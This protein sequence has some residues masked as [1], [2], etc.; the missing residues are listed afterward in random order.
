[1]PTILESVLRRTGAARGTLYLACPPGPTLRRIAHWNAPDSAETI[2]TGASDP[3]ARALTTGEPL[4]T[5]GRRLDVPIAEGNRVVGV[6]AVEWDVRGLL[7]DEHTALARALAD[8][9]ALGVGSAAAR[10][11]EDEFGVRMTQLR[12]AGEKIAARLA[13][14][15]ETHLWAAVHRG[16]RLWPHARENALPEF[17]LTVL[18]TIVEQARIAVDAELAAL[19]IGGDPERPFDP[20]VYAGMSAEDATRIGRVPRPIGLF[21]I[22][23]REGHTVRLRDVR[24]HPSFGGLP[25]HHPEVRSFLAVPIVYRGISLGNIYLGNKRGA[26]EFAIEDQYILE[27]LASQAAMV[28]QHAYL[29]SAAEAQQA[30][31][32]GLLECAPIGILF[33]DAHTGNVV[34]NPRA[35]DLVGPIS[36]EA[37][38]ALVAAR[39][40][41]PDG[42]PISPEALIVPADP[43]RELIAIRPDATALPLFQRVTEV[44]GLDQRVI[45]LL[46]LLEDISPL[47]EI[48]RLREE[49]AAM[50]AHDL[51]NPIQSI[52]LQIPLLLSRAEDGEA[53]VPVA[54]LQRMERTA[55]ALALMVAELLDATRL[56]LRRLSL[57]RRRVDVPALAAD[58]VA[59][60]RM[61]V[62]A[63]EL[64]VR[65]RGT[66]PQADLDAL[67]FDQILTNLVENAAKFSPVGTRIAV[68]VVGADG[69]VEVSVSDEGPGIPQDE[70]PRLFDRFY[71]AET[72]RRRQTGL[73]LGL[74]LYITHGLVEAHGGRIR[75]ESQ[76]GRGTVFRMWFPAAPRAVDAVVAE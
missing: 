58:V 3:A 30:Q 59:R 54:A 13:V 64:E 2:E 23:A 12:D 43:G 50:V 52:L 26:D 72:A 29:R 15:P 73:G 19:G 10:V 56:E 4:Q 38:L 53:H 5:D 28:L 36:P 51:R 21:G 1:M 49:F 44:R 57:D 11:R 39:L 61:T 31:L 76:L 20:W 7:T 25:P 45:G 70:L 40:R 65:A 34:A 41:R 17:L 67:R 68:E 8:V 9:L 47:K 62:P 14:L 27:L 63:H 37:G 42:G 60:L 55:S 6:L 69:G 74:G 33:V 24:D 32:Q 48:T 16:F 66:P 35:M 75:V 18:Q 71:Q 46:V 22:V